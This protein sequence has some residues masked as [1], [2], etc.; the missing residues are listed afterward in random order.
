MV[1]DIQALQKR[2]HDALEAVLIKMEDILNDIKIYK[3][4]KNISPMISIMKN[5]KSKINFVKT[6]SSEQTKVFKYLKV[7][8][9]PEKF[10]KD[11]SESLFNI[12]EDIVCQELYDFEENLKQYLKYA[13]NEKLSKYKQNIRSLMGLVSIQKNKKM[14]E[15][16]FSIQQN[17]LA[18]LRYNDKIEKEISMDKGGI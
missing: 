6:G 17:L 2:R 8:Q 10:S 12:Y 18:C 14:E 3:H 7:S 5:L 13:E 15:D 4:E 1:K 11:I 9:K 16:L